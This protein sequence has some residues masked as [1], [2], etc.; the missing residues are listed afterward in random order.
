MNMLSDRAKERIPKSLSDCTEPNETVHILQRWSEIIRIIGQ[1]LLVILIA[2]GLISSIS[3]T[4]EMSKIQDGFAFGT[5]VSS[6]ITWGIYV[7]IEFCAYNVLV[8]LI[9]SLTLIVHNTAIAANVAVYEASK[10]FAAG[11]ESSEDQPNVRRTIVTPSYDRTP[12]PEGMWKC[13]YCGTNNKN[14]YGQCKKCGKY[15]NQ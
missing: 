4:V 12:T 5:L 11:E 2:F 10:G 8:L 6:L 3:A 15:R 1:T 13:G 7:C 14:Q 9:D